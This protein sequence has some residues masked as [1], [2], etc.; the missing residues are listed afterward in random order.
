MKLKH[1]AIA[2]LSLLTVTSAYAAKKDTHQGPAW[3]STEKNFSINQ[4]RDLALIYQGGSQRIP[5]TEDQIEPY[6]VHKFGNG[7]KDWLF[8]GFLFLEFADMP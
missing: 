7:K 2:F 4:I 1:L 6:V 5:W 3:Q 8:D